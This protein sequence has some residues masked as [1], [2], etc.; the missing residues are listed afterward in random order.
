MWEYCEELRRAIPGSTILIKVH[1]FH[2]GDLA[3]EMVL[4]CGVPYFERLYICF[5]G[6][7]KG[8]LVGYRSFIGLDACYLKNKSRGRLI[9]AVCRD[10]NEEYSPLTYA[11]VE[12]KIKDSWT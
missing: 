12:A 1:T 10:P 7:K 3:A 11:V 4:V 6:H 5:K 2:N 8:F 9:T